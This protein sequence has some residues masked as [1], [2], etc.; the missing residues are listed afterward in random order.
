MIGHMDLFQLK[1]MESS[2]E[3]CSPTQG[4]AATVHFSQDHILSMEGF[5][6][7]D[8]AIFIAG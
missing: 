1:E 8:V 7:E 4:T 2:I 5:R 3:H 6:D